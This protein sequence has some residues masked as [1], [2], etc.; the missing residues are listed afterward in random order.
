VRLVTKVGLERGVAVTF[1]EKRGKGS[2]GTLSY[3]R[4]KTIV[5]D[6]RKEV[7]AGLLAKMLRDLGLTLDDLSR[8]R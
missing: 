7:G 8:R 2:H 5:K 4:R 1:D 3:G 6:R